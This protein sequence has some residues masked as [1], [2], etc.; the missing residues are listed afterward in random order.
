MHN[1]TLHTKTNK[2]SKTNTCIC[3]FVL[4]FL[5]S[6]FAFSPSLLL[7]LSPSLPLAFPPPSL[8][9]YFCIQPYVTH[10]NKYSNMHR[11]KYYSKCVYT[12]TCTC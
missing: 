9:A 4:S 11:H 10:K 7:S 12:T 8:L 2:Q 5:L 6:F 3:S 1:N